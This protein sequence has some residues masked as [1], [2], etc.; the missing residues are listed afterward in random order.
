LTIAG[1]AIE[2]L[3]I[4]PLAGRDIRLQIEARKT[5]ALLPPSGQVSRS[6]ACG[7][8]E[9]AMHT[10]PASA[11]SAAVS[12]TRRTFSRRDCGVKSKVGIQSMPK[13]VAIEHIDH[14]ACVEQLAFKIHRQGRF[15]RTRT[16]PSARQ[17]RTANG[18]TGRIRSVSAT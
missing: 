1:Q 9:A 7:D 4:A 10:K 8:I 6:I 12:P 2:S 15:S 3:G 18:R 17:S 5:A 11:K 14:E 16:A 13:I